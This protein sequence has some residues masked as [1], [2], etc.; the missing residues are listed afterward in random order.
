MPA[1]LLPVGETISWLIIFSL[2]LL[3]IAFSKV[4]EMGIST[5]TGIAT[6][7]IGGNVFLCGLQHELP[8]TSTIGTGSRMLS[9]SFL[10]F[11]G[12]VGE[13]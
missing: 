9:S 12:P 5:L 6:T 8:D 1:G 10:A 3:A 13:G 11:S 7:P 2:L 4:G